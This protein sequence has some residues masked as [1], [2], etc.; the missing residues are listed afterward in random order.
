MPE[1]WPNN[2]WLGDQVIIPPAATE[3]QIKVCEEQAKNDKL[4]MKDWW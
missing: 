4:T 1:N 2:H 3:D